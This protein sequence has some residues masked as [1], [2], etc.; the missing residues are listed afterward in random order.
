MMRVR[1]HGRDLEEKDKF[2]SR[3]VCPHFDPYKQ[4]PKVIHFSLEDL[5]R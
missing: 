5:R 2:I 4:D 3:Q 1:T